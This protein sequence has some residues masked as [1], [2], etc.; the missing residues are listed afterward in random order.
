[1]LS[2]L[3]CELYCV[4]C[5][6]STGIKGSVR[7]SFCQPLCQLYIHVWPTGTAMP[8]TGP[9]CGLGRDSRLANWRLQVI[10]ASFLSSCYVHCQ[11]IGQLS[12][13][14]H[15]CNL[16]STPTILQSGIV[17]S[18]AHLLA[19]VHLNSGSYSPIFWQN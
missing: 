3:Q 8:G 5:T 14:T 1:M 15:T 6:L 17:Q 9:L 13:S 18:C 4:H 7:Y 10:I 19:R 12:S 2:C 16:C 11:T